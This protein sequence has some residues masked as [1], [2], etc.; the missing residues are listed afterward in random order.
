MSIYDN[1]ALDVLF[2]DEAL[3]VVDKPAGL[4]SVPGR[5]V[6]LHD[7][8]LSRVLRQWPDALVVHRL[9][10]P[11]SGVLLF[12]RSREV[13]SAL[14]RAFADRQV[15]KRYVAVVHG[16]LE[17][18]SGSIDLPLRIDWPNR[19]R[20][21]V[22]PVAGKPSVT[23][24]QRLSAESA[25]ALTRLDLRPVT[26]RSHQLRVHLQA[27]GHPI[28][29][30]RLYGPVDDAPRLMLHASH[31]GLMHPVTGHALAVESPAPF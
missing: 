4:P 3:I 22:D 25:P 13:Q 26:G 29:G 16:T 10:M 19:P 14:N 28:V 20:Q 5:P 31:I 18:S 23:H 15:S 24:W 9:D 21:V 1:T 2:V 7:C 8:A 17:C 12:A 6:E 27:L 30:D 11:T